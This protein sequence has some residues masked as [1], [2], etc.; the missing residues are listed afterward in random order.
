MS[1]DPALAAA[2]AA[3]ASRLAGKPMTVDEQIDRALT[4]VLSADAV[5][6]DARDKLRGILKHYAK[7]AH[8]FRACV[9]DNMKRFGPGRTEKVC[10][11]L[12]DVIRGTTRWRNVEASDDPDDSMPELTEEERREILT[13]LSDEDFAALEKVV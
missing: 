4:V 9:R 6:P 10:A 12:K 1:S 11:T 7:D 3:R 13:S 8:P 5:G 2:Q